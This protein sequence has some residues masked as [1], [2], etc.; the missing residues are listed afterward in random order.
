M[1][2]APVKEPEKPIANRAQN[3]RWRLFAAGLLLMLF[4]PALA[5]GL[6]PRFAENSDD[7]DWEFC[8]IC[9]PIGFHV[10]FFFSKHEDFGDRL[11]E[12]FEIFGGFDEWALIGLLAT[13]AGPLLVY[14]GSLDVETNKM[15]MLGGMV[16]WFLGATPWLGSSHLQPTDEQVEI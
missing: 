10:W 12:F 16:V 9:M 11:F 7:I 1:T 13:G 6:L 3:V 5:S 14:T 8:L 4:W 2:K 15:V